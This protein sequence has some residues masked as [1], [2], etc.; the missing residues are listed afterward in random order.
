MRSWIVALT[1]IV[2]SAA[3]VSAQSP[4]ETISRA[5]CSSIGKNSL[6]GVFSFPRGQ[7]PDEDNPNYNTGLGLRYFDWDNSTVQALRKRIRACNIDDPD[8][9]IEAVIERTFI[10]RL[11][12]IRTEKLKYEERISRAADLDREIAAV[13]TADPARAKFQVRVLR[14]RVGSS[15]LLRKD[16]SAL[17]NRLMDLEGAIEEAAAKSENEAEAERKVAAIEAEAR[18]K[19]QEAEREEAAVA[20]RKAAAQEAER[21][22]GERSP[23][24]EQ[25]MTAQ[26]EREARLAAA[27]KAR[28]EADARAKAAKAKNDSSSEDEAR[29]KETDRR[30][31]EAETAQKNSADAMEQELNT[32][33][34]CR[35]ARELQGDA[36]SLVDEI[37]RVGVEIDAGMISE[38]CSRGKKA[39][40][41]AEEMR[42]T[43]AECNPELAFGPNRVV[44]MLR[45]MGAQ[46][47][48]RW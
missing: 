40:L 48:C 26:K 30:L 1:T 15:N 46:Q 47:G 39:Y 28:D 45:E 25:Q 23:G 7:R 16:A 35:R 27:L 20:Q 8:G 34:A 4:S 29:A 10:A 13:S 36:K 33:P 31:A 44:V 6:P 38:A 9:F 5:H 42:A 43:F 21:R 14:E 2:L 24:H 32:S 12:R 19:Q 22:A 11:P 3:P 17:R 41:Q 37:A 18:E